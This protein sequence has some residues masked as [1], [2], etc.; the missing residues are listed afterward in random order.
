MGVGVYGTINRSFYVSSAIVMTA[1]VMMSYT[2]TRAEISSY[3]QKVGFLEM[4]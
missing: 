4:P 3:L 2:R 1:S